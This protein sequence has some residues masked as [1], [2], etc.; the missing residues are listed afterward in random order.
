M[1]TSYNILL[2]AFASYNS[3]IS[4]IVQKLIDKLRFHLHHDNNPT[5]IIDMVIEIGNLK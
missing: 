1:F 5:I 4:Q 3:E 2:F